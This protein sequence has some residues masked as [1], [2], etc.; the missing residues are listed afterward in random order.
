MQPQQQMTPE[1]QKELEEKIKNMSPEELQEFQKQQCIFCQILAGKVPSKKIYEDE[2]CIAVLD[3]NPAAKGHVIVI[4]KEHYAIMPQIPDTEISHL[5]LIAQKMS[6][7][8]LKSLKSAGTSIFVA[9]G[10]AAGQRAQHFMIHVIPRRDGDK[11]LD[12]EDK[13]IDKELVHKVTSSV[14]NKLN[15]H[16]GIKKEVVDVKEKDPEPKKSNNKKSEDNKKTK[17]IKDTEDVGLD[18]IANLF[19]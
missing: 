8:I 15:E 10:L 7:V 6:Q 17:K 9:N 11:I 14:Q 5:F 13:I 2:K 12:V 16:L 19:K 3:V 1:Q 18:D 4:P